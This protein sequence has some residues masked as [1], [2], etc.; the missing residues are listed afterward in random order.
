MSS[1]LRTWLA[2]SNSFHENSGSGG[3]SGFGGDT[4][5]GFTGSEIFGFT[6][7][8]IYGFTYSEIVGFIG[9]SCSATMTF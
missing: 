9:A 1:Y 7:S 8:E 6:G 4:T 2:V 3:A 5:F